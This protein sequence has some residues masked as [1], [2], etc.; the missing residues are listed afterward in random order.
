MSRLPR[1]RQRT[2]DGIFWTIVVVGYIRALLLAPSPAE[3]T[4]ETGYNAGLWGTPPD[5]APY[6]PAPVSSGEAGD[7]DCGQY[8]C[9]NPAPVV[10]PSAEGSDQ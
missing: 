4:G 9:P 5:L 8:G 3:G 2:V 1:R 7:C 6:A 10:P